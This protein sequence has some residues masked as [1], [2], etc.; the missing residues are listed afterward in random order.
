[1][2]ERFRVARVVESW[3]WVVAW[4]LCA[5]EPWLWDWW[6]VDVR[7]ADGLGWRACWGWCGRHRE[8]GAFVLCGPG[9]RFGGIAEGVEE[10]VDACL[11]V[12]ECEGLL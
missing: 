4:R 6:V 2:S 3:P 10:F 8:M 12:A 9:V 7:R 1:M 5:A 11:K